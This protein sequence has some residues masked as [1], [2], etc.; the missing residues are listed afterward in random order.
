[1]SSASRR[2]PREPSDYGLYDKSYEREVRV[3]VEISTSGRTSFPAVL[4]WYIVVKPLKSPKRLVQETGNIPVNVAPGAAVKVE[5]Q[6]KPVKAN[7]TNYIYYGDRSVSGFKIDGWVL[8]LVT[9]DGVE[10]ATS[11]NAPEA[12]AWIKTQPEWASKAE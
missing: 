8:R 9:K 3:A 6:S 10:L 7:D 11:S 12:L 1:M 2:G 5:V 4:R